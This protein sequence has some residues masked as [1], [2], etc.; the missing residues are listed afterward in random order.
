MS[1]IE[2]MLVVVFSILGTAFLVLASIIIAA[3]LINPTKGNPEKSDNNTGFLKVSGTA[4]YDGQGNKIVL[5]GTNLGDWFVQEPWMSVSAINGSFD[6]MFGYIQRDSIEA[7]KNNPNLT[8]EQVEELKQ[9]YLDSFIKEEDFKELH[10]L[11]FN[12]F[13]VNFTCYNLTTDGYTI[14][15]KAFEKLDWVLEMAEKYNLYV[16]LDDHGAI[17]SQNMD[18]HSGD[19][20]HYELYGNKK[21]EDATVE[22]WKFIANRYKDNKNVVI[23]D[24]LN[25]T[26]RAPHKFSGKVQF[27]FY[28]RLYQEIRKIDNNHII[29]MECF[30]FP[31]HGVRPQKYNWENICY[32]YH[33][34]N[35]TKFSEK[36]AINFYRATHN[37]KRY[38][39][40]I[41]IGEYSCWE[42]KKDWYIAIDMFEKL[43][44]SYLSW[45]YKANCY[46]YSRMKRRNFP[47]KLW[48]I[49]ECDIKPVEI[50]EA[51]FE[52]IKE[53]YL[54]TE[55]KYCHKTLI[56]DVFES[57]KH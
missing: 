46:F 18:N 49:Y 13:R 38:K 16:I 11:G 19:D 47:F 14:N 15:P 44:W 37:L 4:F 34:Y 21:N 23:Y 32:S 7:F 26:R 54:K 41:V 56:Y 22:L 12:A 53:T 31:I 30:T 6:N 35:L 29:M 8:E 33:I 9:I 24:L 3:F 42:N 1:S 51:T 57:L 43:G 5:K 36:F 50:G 40:P 52:E 2:I 48:G 25:E 27:D 17:G 10:N 28:D 20:K 45:T 55:T 39:V